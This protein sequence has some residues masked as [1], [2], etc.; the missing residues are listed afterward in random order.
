M[1]EI[2]KFVFRSFTNSPIKSE[3]V[4]HSQEKSTLS[5]SYFEEGKICDVYGSLTIV[6]KSGEIPTLEFCVI[7]PMG[8][9]HLFLYIFKLYGVHVR[10]GRTLRECLGSHLHH[11]G[12]KFPARTFGG[13]FMTE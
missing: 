6:P 4:Y 1:S 5:S 7:G 11:S 8:H 2:Q 10:E 9:P 13:S 3:G 12:S